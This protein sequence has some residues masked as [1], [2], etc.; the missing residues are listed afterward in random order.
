MVREENGKKYL[1]WANLSSRFIRWL[2]V[3]MGV[4]LVLAFFLPWAAQTEGCADSAAVVRDNISGFSL[5][6]EGLAPEAVASPLL[7]IAVIL[8]AVFIRGI[9]LPLTRSV[10]SVLEAVASYYV[11]IYIAFGIFFFTNF[12]ELYGF[13]LTFVTLLSIP[14]VS[15]AEVIVHFPLLDRRGRII[16]IAIF[17]AI[18]L[19]L[20]IYNLV[21]HGQ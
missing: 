4:V 21:S 2:K 11:Y 13:D 17:A 5:V 19:A 15:L 14:Y 16:M 3:A 20:V 8:L 6:Y 12:R 7:G 9:R 18:I 1:R 10:V